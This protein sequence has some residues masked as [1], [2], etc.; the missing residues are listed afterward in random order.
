MQAEQCAEPDQCA[1]GIQ[2]AHDRAQGLDH[3]PLMVNWKLALT[4]WPST[5]STLYLTV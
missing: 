1:G 2:A 4:L 3:G 5:D